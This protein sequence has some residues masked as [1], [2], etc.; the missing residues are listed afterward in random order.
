MAC[1]RELPPPV[2]PPRQHV[3]LETLPEG[4]I[5]AGSGRV[6]LDAEPGKGAVQVVRVDLTEMSVSTTRGYARGVA[7]TK[8]LVC[9]KTPCAV[10]LPAGSHELVFQGSHDERDVSAATFDVT[11]GRTQVVRH[12]VGFFDA[13]GGWKA[14][15][16]VGVTIG[17]ASAVSGGLGFV[18]GS[19]RDSDGLRTIGTV[20]MGG[21]LAILALGITSFVVGRT[22]VQ[23]GSTTQ[24]ALPQNGADERPTSARGDEHVHRE[25]RSK[26]T[27]VATGDGIGLTW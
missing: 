15:G 18:L 9:S 2:A 8:H 10:D 5:P 4:P 11:A 1:T 26:P 27:V 22:E 3:A 14:L 19:Q 6:L 24:W 21:G 25:N 12:S 23:P 17:G 16:V 20:M 13:H 7:V